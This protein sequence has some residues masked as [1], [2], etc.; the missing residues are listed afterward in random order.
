MNNLSIAPMPLS[1]FGIADGSVRPYTDDQRTIAKASSQAQKTA[2]RSAMMKPL[3]PLEWFR[4][5]RTHHQWT[6]FQA[7]RYALWL[8]R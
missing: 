3:S 2:K 1:M 5:L 4:I 8:A 7:I 6:V